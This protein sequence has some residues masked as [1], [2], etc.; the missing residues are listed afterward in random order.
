MP[1]LAP[2]APRPLPGWMRVAGSIAVCLHLLAIVALALGAPSGPWTTPMGPSTS[3]GPQFVKPVTDVAMPNYLE[4]LRMTHNYH[5]V[6]NNVALPGVYFEVHLRDEQGQR[7][8]TVKVPDDKANPWARHRQV[9]LTRGLADDQPVEPPGQEAIPAPKQQAQMITIWEPAE[10]QMTLKRVPMHLIPRDRPVLSPSEWSLVLA[11]SYM[12]HL[13]REHRAAS[14][15]LVRHSRDV[16]WPSYLFFEE[17]PPPGAFEELICNF[18][19]Y[20]RDQ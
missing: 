3:P 16:I 13:C 19:E 9:L 4:P 10:K 18:G 7:I 5:F 14:A 6:S 20:R 2:D 12:R 17:G 15:E 11:Q 8:K 1:H